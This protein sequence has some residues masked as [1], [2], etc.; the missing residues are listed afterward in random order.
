MLTRRFIE[1]RL[2]LSAS[3][4]KQTCLKALSLFAPSLETRNAVDELLVVAL[5]ISASG[6]SVFGLPKGKDEYSKT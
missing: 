1:P 6:I 2:L 3:K 5:H 4:S